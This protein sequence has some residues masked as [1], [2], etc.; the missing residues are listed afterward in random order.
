MSTVR[1]RRCSFRACRGSFIGD[2]RGAVAFE[3]PFVYALII[4]IM[5]LP[6]ADLAIAGFR[7]ISARE[8]LRAFGQSIQYSPPPDVTDP[9][10]WA[11]SAIAKADPSYPISNFRVVC[12]D[13][14][15]CSAANA[16]LPGAKY[17]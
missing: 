9:S 4:F 12:A 17:Y 6:L 5:L 16:V 13:N 10:G 15:T 8:A 3:M 7:Y 14:A 11:A 2:Q 1:N